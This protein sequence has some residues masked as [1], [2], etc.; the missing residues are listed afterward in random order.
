MNVKFSAV[1]TPGMKEYTISQDGSR[2][3]VYQPNW[4]ARLVWIGE[5]PTEKVMAE[6]KDSKPN[7]KS[8]TFLDMIQENRISFILI[9]QFSSYDRLVLNCNIVLNS[10]YFTKYQSLN[11]IY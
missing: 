9:S 1:F 6:M 11:F 5:K 3:A 10:Y 8:G 2:P 4:R 7:K